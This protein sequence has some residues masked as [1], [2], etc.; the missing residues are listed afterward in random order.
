MISMRMGVIFPTDA[1]P[2]DVV[3]WH[4]L[5]TGDGRIT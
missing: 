3:S 1:V 4:K 5:M 2:L